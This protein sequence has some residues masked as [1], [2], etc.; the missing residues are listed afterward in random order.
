MWEAVSAS[1]CAQFVAQKLWKSAEQTTHSYICLP[2]QRVTPAS[3]IC[4]V[5][6]RPLLSRI[7]R[8]RHGRIVCGRNFGHC[9]RTGSKTRR[10]FG[11]MTLI[12]GH[13]SAFNNI[14]IFILNHSRNC[15]KALVFW[16]LH[17]NE[18]ASSYALS[19]DRF[20]FPEVRA[21]NVFP[22][23]RQNM[24]AQYLQSKAKARN[25]WSSPYKSLSLNAASRFF[26]LSSFPKK[27]RCSNIWHLRASSTSQGAL[28]GAFF[29]VKLLARVEPS[30]AVV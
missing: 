1:N 25:L 23:G 3:F 13:E 17:K 9:K 27:V 16:R 30:L 10:F 19:I 15:S 18:H 21:C 12:S 11:T 5:A 14:L 28:A 6:T 2:R 4:A 29:L 20:G 26:F 8:S 7:R 22:R 24:W